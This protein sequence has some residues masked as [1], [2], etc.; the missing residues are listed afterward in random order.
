MSLSKLKS[1]TDNQ[2]TI[3]AVLFATIATGFVP[4]FVKIGIKEIPPFSYSA[5]RF[6]LAAIIIYF[7]VKKQKNFKFIFSRDIIL[8]SLLSTI[9]IILFSFAIQ[10]TTATT[11]QTL[12]ITVPIITA[13]FSLSI[14]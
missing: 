12:Y 3:L 1:T 13:I 9:N 7:L 11:A 10:L 5:L 8:I 6:T 14:I 2:N 4:V